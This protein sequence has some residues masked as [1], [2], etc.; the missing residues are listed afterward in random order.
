ML[1]IYWVNGDFK[2]SEIGKSFKRFIA[3]QVEVA[4]RSRLEF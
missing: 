3:K 4:V 2:I 1:R